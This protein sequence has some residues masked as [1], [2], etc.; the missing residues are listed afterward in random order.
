MLLRISVAMAGLR[1]DI[2]T[3][4]NTFNCSKSENTCNIG[5]VP[6]YYSVLAVA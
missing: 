4:T 3:R 2:R 5:L 6:V 1:D